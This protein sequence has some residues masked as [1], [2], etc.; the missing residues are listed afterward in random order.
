MDPT[1]KTLN[2]FKTNTQVLFGFW[3]RQTLFDLQIFQKKMYLRVAWGLS[4]CTSLV[5]AIEIPSFVS[6]SSKNNSNSR[7]NGAKLNKNLFFYI[8][9]SLAI[10][11]SISDPKK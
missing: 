10:N 7:L 2:D 4:L 8:K 1:L 6:S 9:N 11:R 3:T 5:F